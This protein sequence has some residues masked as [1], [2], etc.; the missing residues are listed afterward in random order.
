[1][2]SDRFERVLVIDSLSVRMETLRFWNRLWHSEAMAR[3]WE[4]KD[5]ESQMADAL[6]KQKA[7]ATGQSLEELQLARERESLMLHRTRVLADLDSA[8]NQGY[9]KLLQR[10]LTFLDEKIASLSR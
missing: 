1:M 10:S 6:E 9:R 2:K 5:V 7:R 8:V 3:G 4:S